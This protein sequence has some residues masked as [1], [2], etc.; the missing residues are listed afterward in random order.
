VLEHL[1]RAD[2]VENV[3]GGEDVV[4]LPDQEPG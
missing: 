2:Q 3:A 1:E 4:E